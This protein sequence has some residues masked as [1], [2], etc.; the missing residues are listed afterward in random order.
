MEQK[1]HLYMLLLGCTP[2]GRLTEQHDIFF[3][4]AANLRDLISEIK[5]FW[6]E[7]K[8]KI[9]I[10]AWR[11][12]TKVGNHTIA[13]ANKTTGNSTTDE[14]LFFLNLGGYKKNE[15][16]EYHYKALAVAPTKSKAISAAKKSTF[17]KHFNIA[18]APSHID[19]QYGIDVDDLHEI[20]DV[21]SASY[22]EK[23]ELIISSCDLPYYDD[24]IHLG[25]LTLKKLATSNL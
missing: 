24:Q 6:P 18:G 3:G 7:A 14:K 19:E 17:Y 10:D 20:N 16:E 8:G 11:Q 4:I 15:F 5:L 25:Y 21:I 12:I 23:Y 9:H 2:E 1:V 22:K 13:V